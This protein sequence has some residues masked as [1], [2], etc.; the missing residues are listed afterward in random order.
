MTRQDFIKHV[1]STQMSLR[2]FL[3]SLCGGDVSLAE[4]LTQEAYVKAFIASDKI[5]VE[6][7][8]K[9]WII[10]IAYNT[11]L[12]YLRQQHVNVSLEE[13]AT[14]ESYEAADDAFRYEN[15][16][17]ALASLGVRDKTVLTLFYLEGYSSKEIAEIMEIKE[18]SVRQS[19]SRGRKR[20]KNLIS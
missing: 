16:H 20:L 14:Q 9:A 10:K 4:D 12:N 13:I 5:D 15:L 18:D 11:F 19:L 17:M 7:N 3:A 8:F 2:R 6:A 1:E